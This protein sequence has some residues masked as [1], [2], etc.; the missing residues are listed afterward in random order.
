MAVGGAA[1]LSHS[2]IQIGGDEGMEVTKALLWS[3]GFALYDR[4]WNDQPPL[5]TALLALLF[6]WCSPTIYIA[7]FLAIA[8]GVGL[9]TACFLSVK[10]RCGVLAGGVA[11]LILLAAPG[12]L[13]LSISVMLEVP[14][15]AAG[16]GALC[17]LHQWFER[18]HVIWLVTSAVMFGLAIQIKMTA[19][20][21]CPALLLEI[22]LL[23]REMRATRISAI[24]MNV[25]V[26]GMWTV[27]T[28]VLVGV[29]MHV[30]YTDAL[31]SH[32]SRATAVYYDIESHRLN[33]M[34]L[35]NAAI[36]DWVGAGMSLILI[37]IS[38][39]LRSVAFPLLLLFTAASVHTLYAPYWDYYCIH[40]AIPLSWL[41]ASALLSLHGLVRPMLRWPIS[42]VLKVLV[43]HFAFSLLLSSLVV[44]GASRLIFSVRQVRLEPQL[45]Q[46]RLLSRMLA[47]SDRTCWVYETTPG[48]FAF[49]AKLTL[50][51]ELAVLPLKRY[52]SG[53]ITQNDVWSLI[54]SYCP[55]QLL[56][57]E[58]IPDSFKDFVTKNYFLDYEEN[59]AIDL[60][61]Y[62]D[63]AQLSPPYA[64]RRLYV[65][66][67]LLH[68]YAN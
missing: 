49:H 30:N 53:Q 18:R 37:P 32:F 66:R 60:Q 50:I 2:A 67:R 64:K 57:K 43:I 65:A 17:I 20:I 68:L 58:E 29:G 47:Y 46:S 11:S 21:M 40:F 15:M 48:I 36:D 28:V 4:V 16:M 55:E 34:T 54:K 19:M 9:I 23:S 62:N 10:H 12:A 5:Y 35:V 39:N 26:W 33:L 31:K 51:P 41:S 63:A 59:S 8:F 7:R 14:A 13:R 42:D 25:L 38:R 56:L 45:Q 6:H 44:L 52:W 61:H 22:V 24:V 3:R 1:V 27:A